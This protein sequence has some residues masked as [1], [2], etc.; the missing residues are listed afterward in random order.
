MI[1][2]Q[3]KDLAKVTGGKIL[4][5]PH[6]QFHNIGTDTRADLKGRAFFALKG[7]SFDA[8]DFLQKA[9][10]QGAS[11]LVVHR[12]DAI[13][14]EIKAKA[15]VVE[16]KDTLV[17]L[18]DL[19]HAYRHQM[20]AKII[21]ITGSN[22]KT[23]TKEFTAAVIG[24]VKKVHY[25]RGSFN[26]HWGV[27]FTILDI[28]PEHEVAIVE[29]GMNHAGE[30]TVLAKIADPDIVTVTMVGRAHMEAFGSIEKVAAAKAEIYEHSPAS[31]A[32][33]FNL[34]NPLCVKMYEKANAQKN[35]GPF[36]TFGSNSETDVSLQILSMNLS[37]L[38]IGGRIKGVKGEVTIPVF[39]KQNITN[40]MAAATLALAAGLAAE[41]VWA[42]LP[43]C[44]TVWGRNQLVQLKSGAQMIFDGYNANPESMRALLENI[45]EMTWS[46][47]K[48]GAFGE[49]LEMGEQSPELHRELGALVAQAG[50]ESVFF[51]GPQA[52]AFEGG[53]KSAGFSKTSFIST[54]YDESLAVK[55]A[56]M[57][58]DGD[59]VVVKGS[60]GMRLER[61]A[62]TC[63]PLNFEQKK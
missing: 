14:E 28:E 11:V 59:I 5:S 46:G 51:I 15:S 55:S 43:K 23:T 36:Y 10:E 22:G 26:N 2:Y 35:Q 62:E 58:R 21:G 41:Q 25:S 54:S 12:T 50:F 39:G 52:E 24:S 61:Y 8:H 53:L 60:R 34:D 7:E 48:H 4:S 38:R 37:E 44:K 45:K 17:A 56:S 3:V 30:L 40:L 63:E 18:Q 47:R 9:V 57:L 13:N 27:P 49:M 42:A 1:P 32:R 33:V 31:A 29:M 20:K 16:V 6:A 19:A